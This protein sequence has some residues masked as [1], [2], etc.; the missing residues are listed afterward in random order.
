[1]N[2]KETIKSIKSIPV[3]LIA[4][5]NWI[6]WKFV[7]RDGKM[8]KMPVD[9]KTGRP[10]KANDSS[11]WAPFTVAARYA[12]AHDLGIGFQFSDTPYVGIDLDWKTFEGEG[13]PYAAEAIIDLLKSYT[14]LSP[15][16]KGIHIIV[17]AE[18][19]EGYKSRATLEQGVGLEVYGHGRM[20]TMTGDVAFGDTV[21]QQRQEE[22]N[23]LLRLLLSKDEKEERVT[24]T[25]TSEVG[26][27]VLEF[28]LK[29]DSSLSRLWNGDI[30]SYGND[31]SRADAAL[32]MKLAFWLQGN[33]ELMDEAFRM[34]ALMRPKWDRQHSANGATYGELTI[35]AVLAE[36]SGECYS[37]QSVDPDKLESVKSIWAT[38]ALDIL[39]AGSDIIDQASGH[40]MVKT[41]MRKVF[42]E[43]IE[44]VKAG[45][46]GHQAG[47]GYYVDFGGLSGL[48]NLLGD[49]NYQ[50][51]RTRLQS[52]ADLGFARGFGKLDDQSA[53]ARY[54]FWIPEEPK[55][56]GIMLVQPSKQII[57]VGAT[58]VRA[59]KSPRRLAPVQTRDVAV[60]AILPALRGVAYR[61]SLGDRTVAQLSDSTSMS[62]AALKRNL[63][64]LLNVGLVSCV[65]GEYELVMDFE[66][67]V[68]IERET[69]PKYRPRVI[70]ALSRQANIGCQKSKARL[71]AINDGMSVREAYLRASA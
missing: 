30:A 19:L 42:F 8:T 64:R 38:A 46:I 35:N 4:Y 50:R 7:E 56:L 66:E 59:T 21:P 14:E 51:L 11:T 44:F 26:I 29:R 24:Q 47:K 18:L 31:H 63:E 52:M 41:S 2:A 61:L 23:K 39:K 20:F 69:M 1:M 15:S 60:R 28:A 70:A 57:L 45:H 36:W 37:A 16:K 33:A 17:E 67:A 54:V 32:C 27:E 34:S 12:A 71:E 3:E 48:A 58:Q 13:L 10:A 49:T 40:G 5:P 53:I 22:L 65:N 68:I 9:P 55:D 25:A 6:C 62:R 43:M